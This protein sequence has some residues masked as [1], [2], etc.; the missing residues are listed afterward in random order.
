MLSHVHFKN[1]RALADLQLSLSPLTVLVG[2]NACGKST[3]LDEIG[4]LCSMS[5]PDHTKSSVTGGPGAV[6][7]KRG[8]PPATTGCDGEQLWQGTWR[9]HTLRISLP[10]RSEHPWL[11]N[12]D[13]S[14]ETASK[15][16]RIDY[17]DM[18]FS[19]EQD[20]RERL[21][22]EQ[23]LDWNY[24]WRSQRL[25]LERR[26]ILAP[27]PI[28]APLNQL[29]PSGHGLATLLLHLAAN[30][31]DAYVAL[32]QDL[33]SVVPGFRRLHV[34]QSPLQ[35]GMH[36]ALDLV[37][38]GAGRIS[39]EFASEGTLLA[40]GLLAAI[41]APEMPSLILL[42]DLDRGLHLSAQYQ[43][44]EAI[45]R[46]QRRRPHLQVICTS[47]SPILVDSFRPDEVRVLAL[48]RSGHTRARPLTKLPDFARWSAALQSGELW[49]N[50]GE[51]WVTDDAP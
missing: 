2:P 29:A 34:K 46:I 36:Y 5:H 14:I 18:D 37:F 47:H 22:M 35:N 17:S 44:I 3:V 12:L 40:L 9:G 10:P 16:Q 49:A 11:S 6:L 42:D 30:E 39:A 27:S 24:A 23:T 48:D 20:V 51:S 33:M 8:V 19:R 45:R 32:Q 21:M 43:L 41:H 7:I 50:F 1:I 26:M 4:R 13:V 15:R 38:D 25:S 31:T 28:D